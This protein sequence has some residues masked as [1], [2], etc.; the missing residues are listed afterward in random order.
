MN[1]RVSVA[2]CP[3]PRQAHRHLCLSLYMQLVTRRDTPNSTLSPRMQSVGRG[4]NLQHSSLSTPQPHCILH[5]SPSLRAGLLR[6]PNG[7]TN[8][9]HARSATQHPPWASEH[10]MDTTLCLL[11]PNPSRCHISLIVCHLYLRGHK[12]HHPTLQ[13]PHPPKSSPVSSLTPPVYSRTCGR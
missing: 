5:A 11:A 3:L 6:L 8:I 1:A 2:P 12:N 9:R 7:L 4:R 13:I 10:T